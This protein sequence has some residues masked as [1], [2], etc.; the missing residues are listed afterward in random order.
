MTSTNCKDD[1]DAESYYEVFE[2]DGDR[3]IISSGSPNHDSEDALGTLVDGGELNPNRR[4]KCGFK[5][6]CP[7]KIQTTL[8]GF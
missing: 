6:L 3:V 2:Y 5:N 7:N 4:C 8:E 1:A